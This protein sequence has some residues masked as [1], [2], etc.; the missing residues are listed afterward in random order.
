MWSLAASKS[1][2]LGLMHS[3]WIWTHG[4][5]IV[6]KFF[7]CVLRFVCEMH[8]INQKG[9]IVQRLIYY[10]IQINW[11]YISLNGSSNRKILLLC[12][13]LRITQ[14]W[15]YFV[16]EWGGSP[17]L[18]KTGDCYNRG[19][20]KAGKEQDRQKGQPRPWSDRDHHHGPWW[21]P[22][23]SHGSLPLL[24]WPCFV[25]SRHYGLPMA[26]PTVRDDPVFSYVCENVP[27]LCAS[28]FCISQLIR[29]KVPIGTF[30]DFYI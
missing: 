3:W 7:K 26:N 6:P 15:F 25:G 13:N 1:N 14:L 16:L 20:F 9:C 10:C 19:L 29:I 2:G 23:S 11:N 5:I 21:T 24:G 12:I 30:S 18:K 27:C 17:I 8:P 4:R 22:Q 28:S